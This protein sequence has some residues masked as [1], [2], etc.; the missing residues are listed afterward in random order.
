MNKEFLEKKT[1]QKPYNVYP[2]NNKLTIANRKK[3]IDEALEC[4]QKITELQPD[5]AKNFI[6]LG[7]I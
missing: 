1:P 6:N 5:N 4:F 7:Y 3:N 2:V